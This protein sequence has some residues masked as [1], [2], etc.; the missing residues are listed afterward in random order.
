MEIKVYTTPTCPWC[1]KLK[2]W[3]KGKKISFQEMDVTESD[4][5]RDELIEKSS[6]M[7]VPVTI[8]TKGDKEEVIVGFNEGKLEEVLE[9]GKKKK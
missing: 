3:L 6:Q 8:V 7:G 2:E 5:A 4:K 1:K 9:K